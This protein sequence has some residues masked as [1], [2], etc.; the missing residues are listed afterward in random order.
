MAILRTLLASLLLMLIGG[1]VLGATT[2]QYRAFT[3]EAARRIAVREHPVEVPAVMLETETGARLDLTAFRGRWVLVDFVYTRCTTYCNALGGDFARLQDQLA[4]PLAHGSVQLLSISLDPERDTPP[5]L[6]GYLQRF[7]NRDS[8]WLA[9]RPVD[10][11]GLARLEKRF[12]ITV[13]SDGLGGF[14]HNV[15]IHVVDPRGRLIEIFDIGNPD[16]VVHAVL[17]RLDR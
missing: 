9:A 10:P 5:R 6:A 17:Q 11:D 13:I 3:T 15:A 1:I 12:G 16:L 7:G 14:T 2:D 8:S 4:G